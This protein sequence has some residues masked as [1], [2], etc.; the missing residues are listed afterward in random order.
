MLEKN[1]EKIDREEDFLLR[2]GS[3]RNDN[4]SK[5]NSVFLEINDALA[6]YGTCI[7]SFGI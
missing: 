2:L 6:E 1:L 4:N 7:I 5:R 3:S